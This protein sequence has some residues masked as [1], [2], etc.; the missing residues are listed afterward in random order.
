MN[1]ALCPVFCVTLPKNR[2]DTKKKSRKSILFSFLVPSMETIT[3]LDRLV[4]K[5]SNIKGV[6][7]TGVSYGHKVVYKDDEGKEQVGIV[8]WYEQPAQKSGAFLYPLA[9]KQADLFQQY[10]QKALALFDTFKVQ[11][12]KEFPESVP[13]TARMNLQGNTVY[14]YFYAEIRFNFAEFVKRFRQ[15]IGYNFFLY[16]VGARDR[17]RLDPKADGMFCASG[18]GLGL[19]CKMYRHPMPNVETDAIIVQQLEGRDIEKLKGLCGKLKCSLN[20]EKDIYA[21]EAQK[22]PQKWSVVTYNQQ[23][24]ICIGFNILTQEIKLKNEEPFQI[25]KITLNEFLKFG[26]IVSAPV[27]YQS[28][29]PRH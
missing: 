20:Y 4:N 2:T 25:I 21:E 9:G 27:A 6:L 29:S 18:H 11:F 15:E 19:D 22:Y 7:P 17:I 1:I 23:R 8:L 3:I 5:L 10:Q 16:Q 14:F 26:K 13:V 12:K 24:M 28:R